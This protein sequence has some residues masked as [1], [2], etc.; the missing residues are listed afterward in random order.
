MKRAFTNNLK[1]VNGCDVTRGLLAFSI[2]IS[3]HVTVL[4]LI[5]VVL[6]CS[7]LL[8]PYPYILAQ[9]SG[10]AT[11]QYQGGQGMIL[12]KVSDKGNYRIQ[13]LWNQLGNQNTSA[14]PSGN[15]TSSPVIPK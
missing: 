12:E 5:L 15:A 6:L 14:I 8:T 1:P 9:T 2:G 7:S 4:S 10:G 11:S 3:R 13:I